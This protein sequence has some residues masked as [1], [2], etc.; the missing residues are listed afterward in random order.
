MRVLTGLIIGILTSLCALPA[1]AHMGGQMWDE[2]IGEYV[3]DGGC[4]QVEFVSGQQNF[5]S[6]M[7]IKNAGSPDWEW[8]EYERLSVTFRPA[9]GNEGTVEL[10][11]PATA[12]SM[13]YL[14]PFV[15]AQSGP[16]T[17]HVEFTSDAKPV[18]SADFPVTV[19]SS[20]S[21]TARTMKAL[22]IG[23][24]I[25]MLVILTAVGIW[26]WLSRTRA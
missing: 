8:A 11:A 2:R 18:I 26:G 24:S 16:Y 7:L 19:L 21:A 6:F 1:S 3:L 25:S 9:D 5:C 12:Q 4:D 13:T 23:G 17:M 20:P 10:S 14:D 15:F 22:S